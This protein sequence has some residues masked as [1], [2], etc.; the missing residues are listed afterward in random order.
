MEPWSLLTQTER[1]TNALPDGRHSLVSNMKQG[2]C[3]A[4]AVQRNLRKIAMRHST[5]SLYSAMARLSFPP[6][7]YFVNRILAIIPLSS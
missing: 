4:G 1:A 5:M 2:E 6:S 7:P 3:Q